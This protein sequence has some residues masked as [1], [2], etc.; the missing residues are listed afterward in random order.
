MNQMR[1]AA[2]DQQ[3]LVQ[4]CVVAFL[5]GEVTRLADRHGGDVVGGAV[6]L[7]IKQATA[8][9]F[10]HAARPPG[11]PSPPRAVSVRAVAQ[12]L[13]VSYETTRR[14]V[15]ALEEEGLVRRLGDAGVAVSP[16]AF[17]LKSYR[18]GAV[19]THREVLALYANLARLGVAFP[20]PP[21]PP[22]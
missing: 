20:A 8:P 2:Q 11:R 16:Q 19:E 9:M 10:P 18:D 17:A 7:A 12:S 3:R 22:P 5:L 1:V 13:K 4:R 15:I 21:S 14:R 6:F